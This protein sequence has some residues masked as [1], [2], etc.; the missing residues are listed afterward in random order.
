M[1]KRH[2]WLTIV[3]AGLPDTVRH[4]VF[5]AAWEDLRAEQRER[6]ARS[7]R[8]SR[9]LVHAA[10]AW[11]T[12]HLVASSYRFALAQAIRR[13]RA[14]ASQLHPAGRQ[15]LIVAQE[16]RQAARLF[17]KQP[18]FALAALGTLAIAIGA[19]T[20][21]FT[22]VDAVL[23]RPLPYP[24][25]DRIV[26]VDETFNGSLGAVSP[27]NFFDWQASSHVFERMALYT[28]ATTTFS[29]PSQA[30]Q[31]T[32][33]LAS[34]ALF[35][36]LGVQPAIG[37]NFVREE[38]R[39]GRPNVAILSDALWKRHFGGDA[40]I[41]GSTV[42]FDSE[43][44]QVVGIMP[45]GF[46]FPEGTEVWL[47]LAMAPRQVAATARGAHY[48]AA[49]ARLRR[50]VTMAAARA[51]MDAVAA[52]LAR[53]YPR[54]N[55]GGGIH[56]AA[57]LDS[58]V[59]DARPGLLVL[60]GAVAC[61]LLIACANVSNLLL[62]RA[63]SRQAEMA[64]RAALGAGRLALVRQVLTESVML[65]SIA[66]A[67][68][69]LLAA[70]GVPA[71][72]VLLPGDVPRLASI[73]VDGRVLAFTLVLSL[74]C[75][76]VFGVVPA[77]HGLRTDLRESL[78]GRR[79]SSGPIQGNRTRTMLVVAEV[80]LA[81]MLLVGA[82]LLLRSFAL[83]SHVNPGFDPSNVASVDLS[84][85]SARYPQVDRIVGF[86]ESLIAKI[87]VRPGV[88]SAGA[89]MIPPLVGIGYGG[90]FTIE[91][92]SQ[93]ANVDEPR[94]QV[95]PITAD[96]FRTLRI[97]VVRGR[98]FTNR[99]GLKD[100]KVAIVS[101][102]A[103]R[104]YWPG[105]DPIGRRVR[106]HVRMGTDA[107]TL[108]EIVGIAGDIKGA[109]LDAPAR[110]VLYVPHAQFPAE[111]MTVVARMAPGAP[112]G[113]SILRDAVREMDREVAADPK[114]LADRITA[115][116]AAPRFRTLLLA[117][118][119]AVALALACIG[120]YGVVAYTVAR[121]THE[122]GVRVALGAQRPDLIRQV[123]REAMT[124]VIAGFGLGLLGALA[125][126]RFISGLLFGVRGDDPVTFAS[127]LVL[128]LLAAL[129]ACYVP[130][131]RATKVDP[132]VTLRAE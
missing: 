13:S 53:E 97:P 68:G 6:L 110:P 45:P 66:A 12:L 20:A 26:A 30:E 113:L 67:A 32:S 101:E 39:E 14:G 84:L 28:D 88:Q 128:L 61:V 48:M 82:G 40:K 31:I 38:D 112:G 124:P 120:L 52:R 96:Y 49:V 56:V 91:G 129:A 121:R 34:A 46:A 17:R 16:V 3:A 37:R 22:V 87:A 44:Y 76:I 43:P 51:E 105:E 118:F 59:G 9:P 98:T 99:D 94:A 69:L 102:T 122:I 7:G 119:A 92:R 2:W 106:I 72:A 8:L 117:L 47:P 4:R 86:Y 111:W 42:R 11:Q 33:C 21:I 95:R 93:A 103:A 41:L 29:G 130:A 125:L 19:N 73:H 108:R 15:Q 107:E 104:R 74:L 36:T 100:A 115:S 131:R 27:V 24:Q 70:W 35:P 123:I 10:A 114:P 126:V 58:L 75:G 1:R 90:T 89:V 55:E 132:I 65:S 109:S 25:P 57:L 77:L 85:P 127:A 5:D 80:A 54:T 60:L 78:G 64:I 71:L 79:G 83:L 63:S 81:V 62:A 18:G 50:G 23:L 116:V